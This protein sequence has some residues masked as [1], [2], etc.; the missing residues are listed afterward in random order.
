VSRF[1]FN[2]LLILLLF[3]GINSPCRWGVRAPE[4][5]R[6]GQALNPDISVG[7]VVDSGRGVETPSDMYSWNVLGPRA[8][9]ELRPGENPGNER[10][11]TH[12]GTAVEVKRKIR[13]SK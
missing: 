7:L 12:F 6:A 8:H 5:K 9:D 13:V 3:I 2:Y 10:C 4:E 11:S 1:V